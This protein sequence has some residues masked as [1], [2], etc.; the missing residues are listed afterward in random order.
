LLTEKEVVVR[1]IK[2]SKNILISVLVLLIFSGC[3]KKVTPPEPPKKPAILK[4]TLNC[5][6][7]PAKD[8]EILL[9][10]Y[11]PNYDTLG[12]DT[13]YGDSAYFYIDDLPS[14][15]VNVIFND[16]VFTGPHEDYFT[17]KVRLFLKKGENL[18]YPG[19]SDTALFDEY[20]RPNYLLSTVLA[21]FD[22]CFD[23]TEADQIIKP[24]GGQIIEYQCLDGL[25]CLAVVLFNP[26]STTVFSM[27]RELNF[28]F[29]VK[30][31]FPDYLIYLDKKILE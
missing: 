14:D 8:V 27:V 13:T 5:E 16:V 28:N 3:S 25:P 6:G 20:G 19:I 11:K 18:F 15:T 12:A 9:V 26:D 23:S 4:G 24:Y 22:T 1:M 29:Y 17:R 21:I 31:A 30:R 7:R 10:E 2:F